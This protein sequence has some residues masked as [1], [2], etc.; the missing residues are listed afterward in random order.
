[1][2]SFHVS[3]VQVASEPLEEI[4]TPDA[5]DA[6]IKPATTADYYRFLER[7][8]PNQIHSRSAPV[9]ARRSQRVLGIEACSRYHGH[10]VS[11]VAFHPMIA[12]LHLA[13]KDHRP[14]ALSPDMIWLLVAQGVASHINVHSKAIRHRFV[15]H[16]DRF[17]L[18]V[19]RDDF[20]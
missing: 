7:F 9:G 18:V 14:L 15:K 4:P 20:M 8:P 2:T 19:R 1:M 6:L 12:A 17:P 13:F 11:G 3:E 10:M 16:A 5:V